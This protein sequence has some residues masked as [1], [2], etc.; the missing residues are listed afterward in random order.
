[1]TVF[2]VISHQKT[3]YI[4]HIY[5]VLAN[6]RKE[7]PASM[8]MS[9]PNGEHAPTSV[10]MTEAFKYHEAP[11]RNHAYAACMRTHTHHAQAQQ[12]KR[13]HLNRQVELHATCCAGKHK[14]GRF[15]EWVLR[16]WTTSYLGCMQR[17]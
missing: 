6:P 10:A 5:M 1:M 4:Y 17:Q 12:Q 9:I 2:L 15:Q 13:R 16:T 14:S 8:K 11:H 7:P 3:L